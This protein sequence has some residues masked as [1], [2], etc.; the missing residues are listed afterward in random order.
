MY[1]SYNVIE[2]CIVIG[3]FLITV[4]CIKKKVYF[5]FKELRFFKRK[6]CRK[7]EIYTVG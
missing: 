1:F 3:D 6:I 7:A 2:Y 4:S 5:L